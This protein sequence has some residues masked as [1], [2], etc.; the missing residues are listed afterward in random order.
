MMKVTLIPRLSVTTAKPTNNNF[1]VTPLSVN[2]IGCVGAMLSGSMMAIASS[3]NLRLI[4]MGSVIPVCP[5]AIP[6]PA[7]RLGVRQK[8]Q[9]KRIYFLSMCLSSI[10]FACACVCCHLSCPYEST[11]IKK[12]TWHV[13]CMNVAGNVAPLDYYG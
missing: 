7:A 13:Y 3:R 8:V 12:H 1:Y 4:G 10:A 6:P 2:V 5:V 11:K 9:E